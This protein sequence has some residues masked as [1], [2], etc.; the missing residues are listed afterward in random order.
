MTT[1]SLGRLPKCR[2]FLRGN[3][4]ATT[5]LH[6]SPAATHSGQPRGELTNLHANVTVTISG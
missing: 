4:R 5:L 2:P 3:V 6:R 1:R